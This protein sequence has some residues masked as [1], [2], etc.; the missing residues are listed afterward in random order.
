MAERLVT[1]GEL[2]ANLG[3]ILDSV[4]RGE[5]VI[6][7]DDAPGRPP[8]RR[9]AL[10]N[11]A[12]YAQITGAPPESHKVETTVGG[13][14]GGLVAGAGTAVSSVTGN[15][16]MARGARK[17]GRRFGRALAVGIDALNEPKQPP[18]R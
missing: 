1:R 11:A 3:P 10:V 6:L 2:Q 17:L 18:T 15:P 7:I 14:A 12:A 9:V 8:A 5:T 16:A 13:V 4:E